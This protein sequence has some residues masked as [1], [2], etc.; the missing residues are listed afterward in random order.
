M[1]AI[2]IKILLIKLL[3]ILTILKESTNV[4]ILKLRNFAGYSYLGSWGWFSNFFWNY[5]DW[6]YCD[7]QYYPTPLLE[8][9]TSTMNGNNQ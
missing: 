3:F 8:F 5:N 2:I 7:N 6:C 4:Y 1:D 9:Y